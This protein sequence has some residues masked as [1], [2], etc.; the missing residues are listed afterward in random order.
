M[1]VAAIPPLILS[2]RYRNETLIFLVQGLHRNTNL[3]AYPTQYSTAGKLTP[4]Q[5]RS[6]LLRRPIKTTMQS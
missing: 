1:S 6:F 2:G 4:T 3:G 5:D